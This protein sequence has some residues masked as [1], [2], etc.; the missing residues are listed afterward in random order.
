MK[1]I[2]TIWF[3]VSIVIS[4]SNFSLRAIAVNLC[5]GSGI[6]TCSAEAGRA[7]YKECLCNWNAAAHRLDCDWTRTVLCDRDE[8]CNPRAQWISD[9]IC[10]DRPANLPERAPLGAVNCDSNHWGGYICGSQGFMGREIAGFKICLCEFQELGKYNCDWGHLVP[11][12][13]NETCDGIADTFEHACVN[14]EGIGFGGIGNSSEIYKP[15][16]F[17]PD[18]IVRRREAGQPVAPNIMPIITDYVLS[19]DEED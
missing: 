11:C 3:V 10:I 6:I 14:R 15:I 2:K 17:K 7:G 18:G 13:K 9:D 12:K 8:M 4:T 19:E 1:I 5:P 16:R